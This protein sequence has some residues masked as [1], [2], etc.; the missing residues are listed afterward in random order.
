MANKRIKKKWQK[1][2]E[3]SKA[4]EM[5]K[6]YYC[7]DCLASLKEEDDKCK[8]GSQNYVS[9]R[10]LV[11]EAG[12]CVCPCGGRQFKNALVQ[13]LG[14]AMSHVFECNDCGEYVVQM[15]FK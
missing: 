11:L 4:T 13:D 5:V 7:I 14:A 3:L 12:A 1:K 10:G 2:R 8:C 9:G 15:I 6:N